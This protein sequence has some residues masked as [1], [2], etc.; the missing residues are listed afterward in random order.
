MMQDATFADVGLKVLHKFRQEKPEQGRLVEVD[1]IMDSQYC[2]CAL[3]DR[4]ETLNDGEFLHVFLTE[5]SSALA[6]E[7]PQNS[8]ANTRTEPAQ[9]LKGLATPNP[10]N[11]AN[12]AS[13]F[14]QQQP[15][16]ALGRVLR[17]RTKPKETPPAAGPPLPIDISSDSSDPISLSSKDTDC[18]IVG[19]NPDST[20]KPGPTSKPL[21]K[22]IHTST[23]DKPGSPNVSSSL[24]K[25]WTL[26]RGFN[27]NQ[28][29]PASKGQTASPST[30]GALP[31]K[32][33]ST[34]T[35]ESAPSRPISTSSSGKIKKDVYEIPSDDEQLMTPQQDRKL[36]TRL[37]ALQDD[38]VPSSRLPQQAN[39]ERGASARKWLS[40]PKANVISIKDSESSSPDS[41]EEGCTIGKT[42]GSYAVKNTRGTHSVSR[43]K[44][45]SAPREIS[46]RIPSSSG[47][48]VKGSF[49]HA[50]PSNH[51]SQSSDLIKQIGEYKNAT[52]KKLEEEARASAA[53]EEAAQKKNAEAKARGK[54]VSAREAI[55]QIKKM[56]NRKTQPKSPM[57]EIPDSFFEDTDLS[58]DHLGDDIIHGP[59]QLHATNTTASP[60][61]PTPRSKGTRKRPRPS[62]S[63]TPINT[64]YPEY[65]AQSQVQPS[66]TASNTFGLQYPK[67]F[68]DRFSDAEQSDEDDIWSVGSEGEK[69]WRGEVLDEGGRL[70]KAF[71]E[72]SWKYITQF[73]SLGHRGYTHVG[74]GP[75]EGL[76]ISGRHRGKY[77]FG[78]EPPSSRQIA[79]EEETAE[80]R[81]QTQDWEESESDNDGDDAEDAEE[82]ELPPCSLKLA[83]AAPDDTTPTPQGPSGHE[84]AKIS[85]ESDLRSTNSEAS[86]VLIRKQL[87][88]ECPPSNQQLGI[89]ISSSPSKMP[90]A[91]S[92]VAPTRLPSTHRDDASIGLSDDETEDTPKPVSKLVVNNSGLSEGKKATIKKVTFSDEVNGEVDDDNVTTL[93]Q[94]PIAK[95]TVYKP[96]E[97]SEDGKDGEN[98][99]ESLLP[100]KMLAHITAS[101]ASDNGEDGKGGFPRLERFDITSLPTSSSRT[102]RKKSGQPPSSAPPK[103]RSFTP[104]PLPVIPAFPAAT[105]SRA[106]TKD[107]LLHGVGLERKR[108]TSEP[109]KSLEHQETPAHKK[110][111]HSH[112]GNLASASPVAIAA[113]SMK[114]PVPT[115][116]PL[117]LTAVA[118]RGASP[119]SPAPLVIKA[120]EPKTGSKSLLPPPPSES[121]FPLVSPSTTCTPCPRCTEAEEA[122]RRRKQNKAET[123]WRRLRRRRQKTRQ[124]KKMQRH[125]QNGHLSAPMS[126]VGTSQ[127]EQ[128]SNT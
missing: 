22:T 14:Q 75:W 110:R 83:H 108:L 37:R 122:E 36:R 93:P 97:T 50:N 42:P 62:T 81:L 3:D 113:T 82:V 111:K 39:T 33:G 66:H 120:E 112:D 77:I 32:I 85:D 24:P 104:V 21:S 115:L 8:S 103:L 1:V 54:R 68:R 28:Q 19:E 53:A 114:K 72:Y 47:V 125:G 25:N 87:E 31:A 65:E 29:E 76:I 88:A 80:L 45:S 15:T 11:P 117:P 26:P 91:R 69:F 52:K 106:A 27:R 118:K 105:H 13:S 78:C 98:G 71:N 126:A 107:P 40:F 41:D 63:F 100:P 73:V 51:K 70:P 79:E 116:Q 7:A 86:S 124:K 58:E 18:V 23:N 102:Q 55:D 84:V 46:S 109:P 121:L 90:T 92:K 49:S 101:A 67:H 10:P 17:S 38:S 56:T 61:N 5:P 94:E 20:Q 44:G 128:A 123:R 35:P 57:E 16:Q 127:S 95:T 96:S 30:A 60:K 64:L 48:A 99:D 34:A 12:G 74:D 59:S 119:L 9:S 2:S 89:L 6:P 43:R 4:L